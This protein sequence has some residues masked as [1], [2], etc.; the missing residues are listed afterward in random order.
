MSFV[1]EIPE[2]KLTD[3]VLLPYQTA[4]FQIVYEEASVIIYAII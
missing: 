2:S 4:D 1:R 3:E